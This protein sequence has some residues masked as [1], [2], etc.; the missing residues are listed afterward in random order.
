MLAENGITSYV[1]GNKVEFDGFGNYW[2]IHV[3][4]LP[5]QGPGAA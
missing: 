3:V 5:V 4:T 2:L 1:L